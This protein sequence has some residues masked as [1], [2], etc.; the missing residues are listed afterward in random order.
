MKT[1]SQPSSAAPTQ[2]GE[3]PVHEHNG[4]GVA[5]NA[6]SS[7]DEAIHSTTPPDVSDGNPANCLGSMSSNTDAVLEP[8]LEW[9][10]SADLSMIPESLEALLEFENTLPSFSHP[11]SNFPYTSTLT[12]ASVGAPGPG[13][14]QD[15]SEEQSQEDIRHPLPAAGLFEGSAHTDGHNVGE[16]RFGFGNET[17]AVDI[18]DDKLDTLFAQCKTFEDF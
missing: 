9:A 2:A 3:I 4:S 1:I 14:L 18:I 8:L 7:N 12:A 5:H 11:T 13:T 6:A 17:P 10:V 16:T 15:S